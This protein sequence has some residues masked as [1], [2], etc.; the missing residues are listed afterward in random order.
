MEYVIWGI[1]QD[2]QDE[3][4]LFTKAQSKIEAERV[5]RILEIKYKVKKCRI[6]IVDLSTFPDFTETLNK[7]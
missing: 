2:K 7:R 6:Q 5:C 3:E 1:P 4:I